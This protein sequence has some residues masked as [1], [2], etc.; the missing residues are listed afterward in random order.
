MTG[1]TGTG[2][3]ILYPAFHIHCWS[4]DFVY[5]E[6]NG[7]RSISRNPQKETRVT[8]KTS[9]GSLVMMNIGWRLM[10]IIGAAPYPRIT[11]ELKILETVQ[12]WTMS[13]EPISLVTALLYSLYYYSTQRN[14]HVRTQV[15][16][17]RCPHLFNTTICETTHLLLHVL[18]Y[19]QFRS[20][21][22][23]NHT[24]YPGATKTYL[25]VL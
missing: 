19:L 14:E 13:Q 18:I 17:P 2:T 5:V 6:G 20:G 7:W 8:R 11:P 4:R 12:N 21:R 24:R 25:N 9:S 22:L 3:H 1:R 10:T 23:C 15:L 16:T